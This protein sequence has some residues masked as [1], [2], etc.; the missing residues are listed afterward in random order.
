MK[1]TT[2]KTLI[3][4]GG[5]TAS[6]KTSLAIQL[7]KQFNT[8]I[9]SADSRQF[10]KELNI[11]VARPSHQEL[12]AVK[13]H[14]IANKSIHEYYSAGEYEREAISV[15][16]ELYKTKDVVVMV[17]GSGLFINAVLNGFHEAPKDDGTIRKEIDELYERKGLVG[18]QE[19]HLK[20]DPEYNQRIDQQNPQRLMRAIERVRLTGKTHDQQTKPALKS[21]NFNTIEIAI[22]HP[23]EQL[24][25]RIN[26]RVDQM[27]DLGLLD[28]VKSLR[29]FQALNSLQTVGYTE[30]FAYLNG[31]SILEEAID[32]IKQNTRRYAKRQVTW[33]RNKSK[34]VWIDY[35]KLSEIETTI[36]K[37]LE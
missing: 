37:K 3:V 33:F 36:I 19:L 28:E 12:N 11:G 2:H 25:S 20:M 4:V 10:Y 9:L 15:L 27:M 8:E 17:G 24:Y 18:L 5:P 35:D 6:G 22:S 30:L 29:E 34:T 13:H 26:Q 1:A 32:K 16:D 23:R 31:E 7:A 21:R 14:F